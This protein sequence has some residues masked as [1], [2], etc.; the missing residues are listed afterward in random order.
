MTRRALL[1]VDCPSFSGVLLQHVCER[2]AVQLTNFII[3]TSAQELKK[4][5]RPGDGVY[6]AVVSI[7]STN[8]HDVQMLGLLIALARPGASLFVQEPTVASQDLQNKALLAGLVDC[9]TATAYNP[10]GSSTPSDAEPRSVTAVEAKKP[11][12]AVGAQQPIQRKT[13]PSGQSAV[14]DSAA[15]NAGALTWEAA[16]LNSKAELIDDEDLLTD[17]DRARPDVPVAD[18]STSRKACKDC[19]CGRAEAEA[20]GEPAPKLTVQMLENPGSSGGCGSCALGDAFRCA[21]C[22]YRGLPT[23]EMGKKIELPVGFLAED[24]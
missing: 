15:S 10:N 13:K 17:A 24:F 2:A 14:S 22:P 19:S 21:S 16:A 11:S 1:N 3:V 8:G 4:Q 7:S 18:C 12:W 6:D 20:A 5:R 9:G 23:F